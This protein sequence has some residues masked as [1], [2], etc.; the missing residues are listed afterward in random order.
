MASGLASVAYRLV[1]KR[2]SRTVKVAPKDAQM[3]EKILRYSAKTQMILGSGGEGDG[4][5]ERFEGGE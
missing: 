4:L 2:A 3:Y 5:E 1:F